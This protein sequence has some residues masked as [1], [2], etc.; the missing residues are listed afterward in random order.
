MTKNLSAA[1]IVVVSVAA[2]AFAQGPRRDGEWEV[3]TEMSMPG[4]PMNMPPMTSKQCI[5]PAEAADPQKGDA[6][7]GPRRQP[8]RL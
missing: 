5:T 2:L 1:L 6:A 8:E 7:A 4:M 3:K